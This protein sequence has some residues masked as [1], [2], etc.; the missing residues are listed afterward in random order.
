[1]ADIINLNFNNFTLLSCSYSVID[2]YPEANMPTTPIGSSASSTVPPPTAAATT[3]TLNAYTNA[4]TTTPSPSVA[5]G[6][7]PTVTAYTVTAAQMAANLAGNTGASTASVASSAATTTTT[8]AKPLS[9]KGGIIFPSVK[10]KP[11]VVNS[12][13]STDILALK[14]IKV[15]WCEGRGKI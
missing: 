4:A 7:Q 14:D 12:T 6:S 11:S 10:N 2:E 13:F 9:R 3:A 8:S 1:M 15:S 5:V